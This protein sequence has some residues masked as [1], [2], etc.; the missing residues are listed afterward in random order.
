[1]DKLG[2]V[3]LTD[4]G[5]SKFIKKGETTNS[6]CGTKEYLSP[7]MIIGTGHDAANDWWGVGILTYEIIFGVP[8]FLHKNS[9]FMYKMIV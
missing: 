5:M 4:Y 9:N 7:E 6:F 8:P 3:S 1:M 2:Y